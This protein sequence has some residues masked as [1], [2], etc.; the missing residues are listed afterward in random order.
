MLVLF[1]HLLPLPSKHIQFH[2]AIYHG[3]HIS[4]RGKCGE[5]DRGLREAV[6]AWSAVERNQMRHGVRDIVFL[7]MTIWTAICTV[8]K[9]VW[10]G[11][12]QAQGWPYWVRRFEERPSCYWHSHF[13]RV[14]LAG[15]R[16]KICFLIPKQFTAIVPTPFKKA[17]KSTCPLCHHKCEQHRRILGVK[18]NGWWWITHV[19]RVWVA[20]LQR[21]LLSGGINEIRHPIPSKLAIRRHKHFTV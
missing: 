5:K 11:G 20:L 12:E 21:Q 19:I 4:C 14:D 2:S 17:E 16:W 13:Q 18:R 10:G 6:S 9:K 8:K 1:F 3:G 7:H 15:E